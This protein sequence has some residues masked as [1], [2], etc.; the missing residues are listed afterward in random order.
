MKSLLLK[1]SCLLLLLVLSIKLTA[2]PV[3]TLYYLKG[4]PQSNQLNPAFQPIDNLYLGMPVLSTLQFNLSNNSLVVNDVLYYDQKLDKVIYFLNKDADVNAKSIFLNKLKDNTQIQSDFQINLADF[5]FRV[6]SYY[7]SFGIALKNSISITL[8]KDFARF[9][10][11]FLEDNSKY[12]L[13]KMRIS[14]LAYTEYSMGVSKLIGD[15]LQVGVRGKILMGIGTFQTSK[16]DIQLNTNVNELN[17]NSNTQADISVPNLNIYFNPTDGYPD[18]TSMDDFTASSIKKIAFNPK[19]SGLAIDLGAVYKPI[20]QIS[21]S[22][23][24][25]D[26]GRIWW[27]DNVYNLKQEG[28]YKFTGVQLD[29]LDD[30][31]KYFDH[32]IDTLKNNIK[33]SNARSSFSTAL[34]TKIFLG[35]EFNPVRWFSL[36]FLSRT[37]I[38]PTNVLQ[39]FTASANI[40]PI[41]MFSASVSYSVNNNSFNS[42]GVGLGL[43]LGPM[44]MYMVSDHIPLYYGKQF[45][46]YKAGM[47]D[48]RIGFN[49]LFGNPAKK[50]KI[51]E[52]P[53]MS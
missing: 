8:P 27:K 15:K 31:S 6:N 32:Y 33:P 5:G 14:E 40:M 9:G 28:S 13:S 16:M 10:L 29:I 38:Y 23:S 24:V 36:G 3:N 48:F 20:E 1:Y 43:K 2:Q 52:R 30:T 39:E 26:L 11:N 51:K 7:F 49:L 22:A 44:H 53:M 12:D 34:S 21:L 37:V 47:A 46:P 45:I 18:S 25:V 50:N 35:A 4:V 42:L 41:R 17:I 19:N